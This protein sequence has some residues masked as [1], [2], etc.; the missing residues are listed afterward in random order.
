[1]SLGDGGSVCFWFWFKY[2]LRKKGL[3]DVCVLGSLHFVPLLKRTQVSKY[4]IYVA[5]VVSSYSR[6][7]KKQYP[8]C[9]TE[10][11]HIQ[12]RPGPLG[13]L[14]GSSKESWL[15]SHDI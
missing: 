11:I 15:K 4:L 9:Y 8:A 14:L 1:M 5:K 3:E 7:G 10:Y 2:F 13:T 12:G 6:F